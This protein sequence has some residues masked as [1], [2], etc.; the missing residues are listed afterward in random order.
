[1]MKNKRILPRYKQMALETAIRNPE[2]YKEILRVIIKN[3]FIK[4]YNI[5]EFLGDPLN[6]KKFL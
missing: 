5:E 6:Q 4:P 1:M 3:V 2:R